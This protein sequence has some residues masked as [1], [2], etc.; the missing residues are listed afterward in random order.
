MPLTETGNMPGNAQR[1][2]WPN[3]TCA[4]GS[5]THL[6]AISVC[7]TWW[8]VLDAIVSESAR[9]RANG[10]Y[11]SL[12]GASGESPRA[13]VSFTTASVDIVRECIKNWVAPNAWN[14]NE[15]H[16]QRTGAS[17]CATVA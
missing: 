13:S 4:D 12:C 8:V 16:F 11:E 3:P 15:L 10:A 5:I 17:R 2:G 14:G 7:W 1:P 9:P 6:G